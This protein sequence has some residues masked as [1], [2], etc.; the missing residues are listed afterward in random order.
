MNIILSA[1]FWMLFVFVIAVV[2][3][4]LWQS[5]KEMN[6]SPLYTDCNPIKDIQIKLIRLGVAG[7]PDKDFIKNDLAVAYY[8]NGE[9]DKAIDILKSVHSENIASTFNLCVSYLGKND[10]QGARMH[11]EIFKRYKLSKLYYYLGK[12]L[13][14]EFDIAYGNFEKALAF[15]INDYEKFK[16]RYHRVNVSFKLAIIYGNLGEFEKQKELFEYVDENGG[17]LYIV[18][19]AREWLE[20]NVR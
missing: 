17:Q 14:A 12:R 13:D 20:K 3:I 10:I 11:H 19:L 1:L 7:E 4:K 9:F 2:A 6:K 16:S 18:K 8:A 5:K 15:Y